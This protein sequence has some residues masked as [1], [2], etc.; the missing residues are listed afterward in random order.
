MIRDKKVD[1]W[2]MI[3]NNEM[4]EWIDDAQKCWKMIRSDGWMD[5]WVRDKEMDGWM[6]DA[7]R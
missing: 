7:Q 6:D 4:D 1:E 3:E 5:V 2:M